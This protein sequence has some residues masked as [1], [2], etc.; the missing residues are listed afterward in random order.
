[1]KV[2]DKQIVF[3]AGRD[4]YNT[5]RIPSII[6]AD[7]GALIAFCE[8]RK[9]NRGDSGLIEILAK[10]SY[11]MGKTWSE[12]KI[13]AGD[14]VNTFGNCCPVVDIKS[15]RIHAVCNFNIG[16]VHE[17]EI[18]RGEGSRECFHFFSDDEGDTWS[19]P[20][21][22][23]RY[24]KKADWSWHAIG[25]CHGIQ[26][27]SGRFVFGCNHANL[28]NATTSENYDG[29][30]FSI[31]SDDNCKTFSI[32]T[33]ISPDTNECS[34]AELSDGRLYMNMRTQQHNYRFR[35]YSSNGGEKWYG[36]EPDKSLIDP[37]CQGSVLSLQESGILAF[38]NA[39]SLNRSNLTLKL[40]YDSGE[41]W[42][43][44]VLIHEGPAAYSD[45]VRINDK[46]IGC[47]YEYGSIDAYEHIGIAFIQI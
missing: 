27:K 20:R 28:S 35:A 9:E 11:D 10:K 25:P 30:S 16:G 13:A 43:E 33:D 3:S 26:T 19:V 5:Y 7:S 24:A 32:S 44:S 1:M 42:P 18:R 8:G 22:I 15:G 45:L 21:N 38:C 31:Y 36:F 6:K 12:N 47:L 2:I 4:G 29:Y 37:K 41:T 34:V 40:S 17:E 14:N 23:T 39:A 46:T